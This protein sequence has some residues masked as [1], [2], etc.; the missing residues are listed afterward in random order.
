V[1]CLNYFWIEVTMTKLSEQEIANQLII[2]TTELLAESGEQYQREVKMDMSLQRHL[3]IDS[4]GRSEL[5]TRIE[6][7]FNVSLPDKLLIQAETLNDIAAQ[8]SVLSPVVDLPIKS[9]QA[10]AHHE[11]IQVDTSQAETLIDVLLLF[12]KQAPD[13]GHIFFQDENGK[14]EVITYGQML[15][16]S[17]R[18][19][20]GL[21]KAG[22]KEGETVAIMQ[23]THPGFFY[24]FYGVL[25]A[26]GIPVPIYPPFRMH[27]LE[28]Y[29]RTEAS[30]LN[31]AEVRILVTFDRAENLSRLLQT[32]VRSLRLVTTVDDL[33]DSEE[34]QKPYAAKADSFAFIQ[35]TSGST[36]DPKGVLLSHANLLA[37]IRAYGA[38]INIQPDDVAVSWLPLYHDMGLIGMWF[39]SLYFGVPLILLTPFTFLNRPERWLWAIHYHRGTI[40]AAPNFA[41][42]L[43][44]RKIDPAHL[45]G[46]DLSSWRIAAN[47][48]E[49][50]YPSTLAEF[51]RKFAHFGLKPTTLLPVYGLAESTVG[52][53]IPP[54]D[55]GYLVD[56]VDRQQFE[57]ER[58]A[59]PDASKSGLAFVCCGKALVGH[60]MRIVNEAGQ[61]L[62]ERHV[63]M[64]QFRGPSSMQ[65]YYNNPRATQAIYQDG[66]YASGDLA[67]LAEGEVYITGRLK[68]LIIKAGR[69]LYPVEIEEMVGALD[70]VRQ[71]CVA[72]FGLT[73]PKRGTEQLVI[74][75]ETREQ[76]GSQ[77]AAMVANIKEVISTNL[78]I[79]PDHV[80]LV[81]PHVVPKTSSGKLQ[82]SACKKMYLDGKLNRWQLPAW[83]QVAKLAIEAAA[84]QTK[85]VL[86][87]VGKLIYTAYALPL[88][89]STLLLLYVGVRFASH[90]IAQ[91]LCRYWCI[92]IL[93]AIGCPI[94]RVGHE[95]LDITHPVIFAANHMSYLD[96]VVAIAI[97]PAGTRFIGK[98][99]LLSI[100]LLRTFI[101]KL[102]FIP[103]D[104]MDLSKGL[105]DAKQIEAALKAGH[106]IFIFPEG[107][108]SYASGLR[109]FRMGAFKVAA[110]ANV[111]I[112]P[113]AL[114]GT[115]TI[116]RG[117]EK[118]MRPARITATICPLIYPHGAEWKE[119]TALRNE[120]RAAI[121]AHCGEPLLDFIAAQT[122]AVKPLRDH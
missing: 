91:R 80:I 76:Q 113:I 43:C 38:A 6:K 46:L 72:A 107:T 89:F 68:D 71:G 60:E 70:G 65:G 14:E 27:M 118:L 16:K 54:L 7:M 95:N 64:L 10:I 102:D 2:I 33:M 47:G 90:A 13:K 23:P 42:E 56:Y 57:E 36:S 117:D 41:Y 31:S 97:V 8:L 66:W 121:A 11:R 105:Q 20:S 35:Y 114:S 55:R 69:N 79:V 99:E 58:L 34:W 12:A 74:V 109:P 24:T 100:P 62:P 77:R 110:E 73:D 82:R 45:E 53:A 40:S 1:K 86:A 37:N 15:S 9:H 116:L 103:V 19:A 108:F 83:C 85:A 67:Y 17:L 119:V 88:V 115:R 87:W 49:K 106:S 92:F 28:A 52:L 104:R 44:T 63:G 18:V 94:K 84:R 4:L 61:V 51:N 111:P 96:A 93:N 81:K 39:G 112:C 26:G 21:R 3:G 78:D 50:I 30:I 32:F 29:A 59:V 101:E 122:V 75:A 25:L 5:F 22:L 98:K 48:A 120:V